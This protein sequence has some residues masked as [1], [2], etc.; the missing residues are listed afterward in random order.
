MPRFGS[1]EGQILFLF[2]KISS[3]ALFALV[4]G[5]RWRLALVVLGLESMGTFLHATYTFT[6]CTSII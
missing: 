1:W 5:F 2:A 6:G 4:F 3:P